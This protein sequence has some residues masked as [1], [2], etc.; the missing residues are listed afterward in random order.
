MPIRVATVRAADVPATQTDFPIFVD[1]GRVGATALTLAEAESSRWYTDTDLVTQMAREIVSLTEGHGKYASLTSTSKIAID[2]DGIRADYAVG[3]T[4]GRNAVWSDYAR[5]YHLKEGSGNRTDSTGNTDVTGT[6]RGAVAGIIGNAND[7]EESSLD[8]LT[9]ANTGVVNLTNI[10]IEIAF[11]A[12]SFTDLYPVLAGVWDD[13]SG[14][15]RSWCLAFIGSN[16]YFYVSDNTQNSGLDTLSSANLSTAT[17][18]YSTHTFEGL[19]TSNFH[20]R[21]NGNSY[22]KTSTVANSVGN[23]TA[24]FTIGRAV[25]FAGQPAGGGNYWDGLIDEVRIRTDVLSANWHTTKYNNQSAESTFWGTWT[26]FSGGGGFT[27]NP[28]M[29][30]RMMAGGMV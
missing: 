5:V 12:E 27:P 8:Y 20:S 29:H 16:L 25:S 13:L 7:F 2:Y 15:K 3:D 9:S 11:K 28:L 23:P 10:S 14:D 24:A 18:Y 19:A 26:T 4:F 30:M 21:I 6:T 22:T 1:L 17:N